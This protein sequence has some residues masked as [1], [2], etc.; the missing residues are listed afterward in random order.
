MSS[1]ITSVNLETLDEQRLMNGSISHQ[2]SKKDGPEEIAAS[3]ESTENGRFLGRTRAAI[4]IVQL[5]AVTFLT[6][7]STGLI[8]VSIPRIAGD[9]AIQP[10]L[11]YW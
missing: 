10:Q 11:Y 7:I 8:T 9:L 3:A 6:S 1:T 5:T 2:A 4:V